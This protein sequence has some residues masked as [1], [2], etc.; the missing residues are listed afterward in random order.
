[1]VKF[2]GFLSTAS[3][4][5]PRGRVVADDYLTAARRV[6][7]VAGDGYEPGSVERGLFDA[8]RPQ[9]TARDYGSGT[10][11][12][13][14][15]AIPVASD[16][17]GQATTQDKWQTREVTQAQTAAGPRSSDARPKAYEVVS[18]TS[19][20]TARTVQNREDHSTDARYFGRSGVEF[21]SS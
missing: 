3:F 2:D 6:A 13:S 1:L 15:A 5:M 9:T 7:A 17:P 14:A 11:S 21:V 8:G 20:V 10:Q 19:R 12:V 18:G 16:N 4:R